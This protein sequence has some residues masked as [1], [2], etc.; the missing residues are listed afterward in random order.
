[1]T[2]QAVLFDLDDTLLGNSMNRFLPA[3]FDSIQ[4]YAAPRYGDDFLQQMQQ[5]THAMIATPDPQRTNAERFWQAMSRLT[6]VTAAEAIPFF[7][8]YYAEM[9]PALRETI[10]FRPQARQV[11]DYCFAQGWQVVIATNPLFPQTAI[12]Q[13]LA[14]ADVPVT[15]YDYALVTTYENMHAAKPTPAYYTEILARID[16][17]PA[18]AVM[19]GDSVENDMQPSQALGMPCFWMKAEAGEH[20]YAGAG[21][22]DDFLSY[23][24]RRAAEAVT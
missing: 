8:K 12:E 7:T 24:Q 6:D 10:D 22:L 20:G 13:R 19:V 17:A 1:M 11:V 5:A 3:Y 9:Y 15:D 21:D 18:N 2:L 14:W 4:Q 16:C 23:L